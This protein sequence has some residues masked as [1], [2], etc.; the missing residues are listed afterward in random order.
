[1]WLARLRG[2][3]CVA[4]NH[5]R[6]KCSLMKNLI[7]EFDLM[8][9]IDARQGTKQTNDRCTYS[10]IPQK[11]S[12]GHSFV[13][14]KSR[15]HSIGGLNLKKMVSTTTPPS[16]NP[17]KTMQ[18][19]TYCLILD[20]DEVGEEGE[21]G[22]S[23][24]K[25][26]GGNGDKGQTDS[27]DKLRRRSVDK[28]RRRSIDKVRRRGSMDTQRS[29]FD[30]S[31]RGSFDKAQRSS[32]DKS[33]RPSTDKGGG[34][35]VHDDMGGGG[36][37]ISDVGKGVKKKSLTFEGNGTFMTQDEGIHT[38]TPSIFH[39]VS[40]SFRFQAIF[41]PIIH[42]HPMIQPQYHDTAQL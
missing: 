3:G 19:T 2:G 6:S 16:R 9:L 33:Q 20:D 34:E 30:K 11:I 29:S 13:R 14:K 35:G 12:R 26:G 15:S 36:I 28:L 32:F 18:G 24:D 21:E 10:H 42:F 37:R 41:M 7:G 23:A 40:C 39:I 38:H 5:K 31:Q 1:M 25:G 8:N 27:I 17:I 4:L 22:S